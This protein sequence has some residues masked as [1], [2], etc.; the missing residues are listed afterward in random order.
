MVRVFQHK[1]QKR[2]QG[3]CA[4]GIANPPGEPDRTKIVPVGKTRVAENADTDCG[5]DGGGQQ[6]GQADK[7]ENVFGS[8]EGLGT[9]GELIGQVSPHD[10]LKCVTDGD[11]GGD[12][13]GGIDMM[14]DEESAGKDGRPSTIAEKEESGDGDTG[15][16]PESGGM[17]IDAGQTETEAAASII[18]RD[19]RG[20]I[21]KIAKVGGN[22]EL[23]R[24]LFRRNNWGA[25]SQTLPLR[26]HKELLLLCD[27]TELLS[28]A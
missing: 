12:N 4:E 17:R 26:M 25:M 18:N 3:E 2:S 8:V 24:G 6:A 1:D 11:A 9:V 22:R 13:D 28:Y 19:K 15:R 27:R 23:G 5:T 16:C 10:G 14:I 7:A 21:G 20:E